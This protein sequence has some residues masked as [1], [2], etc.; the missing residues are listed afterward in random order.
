MQASPLRLRQLQPLEQSR[1][2]GWDRIWTQ[3]RSVGISKDQVQIGP[4][5][6]AE[7]LPKRLLL[8]AMR[9]QRLDG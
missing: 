5:V 1:D 9:F 8:L 6:C 3:W 7:L 2:G 4:V